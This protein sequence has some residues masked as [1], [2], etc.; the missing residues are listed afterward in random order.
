G[1]CELCGFAA[2]GGQHFGQLLHRQYRAA[3]GA[4]V[5]TAAVRG[6]H[7]PGEISHAAFCEAL[8][9]PRKRPRRWGRGPR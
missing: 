6:Q 1:V 5:P 3:A 2:V 8:Y 9:G 4:A 7:L